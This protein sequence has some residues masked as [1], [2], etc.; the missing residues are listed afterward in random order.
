[1]NNKS[2]KSRALE[3]IN[4]HQEGITTNDVAVLLDLPRHSVSPLVSTL[5]RER[6]I[7]RD[8]VLDAQ[9]KAEKAYKYLPKWVDAGMLAE[10]N[11]GPLYKKKSKLPTVGGLTDDGDFL[12]VRDSTSP[13]SLPVDWFSQQAPV[14]KPKAPFKLLVTYEMSAGSQ[15]IEITKEQFDAMKEAFEFDEGDIL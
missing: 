4:A 6:K 7:K 14:K 11:M 9:G 10:P 2:V 5:W 15:W 13:L 1:M 3:I 8:V 12:P